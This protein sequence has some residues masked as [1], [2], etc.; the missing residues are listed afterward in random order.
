MATDAAGNV[1]PVSSVLHF[2]VDTRVAAALEVLT[3]QEEARVASPRPAI[4]GTAAPG[5]TVTVFLDGK[6]AGSA[7]ADGKGAWTFIPPITLE[8]GEHIVTVTA[9]D[10]PGSLSSDSVERHFTVDTLILTRSQGQGCSAS[11]GEPSLVLLGLAALGRILSRRR[12][13]RT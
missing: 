11:P 2:T 9:T 7:M 13:A 8:A 6:R 5:S 10:A 1:S 4:G 12:P 3:P